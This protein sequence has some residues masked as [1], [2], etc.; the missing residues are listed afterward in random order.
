M[1]TEEVSPCGSMLQVFGKSALANA[2]FVYPHP[3]T[4]T[5]IGESTEPTHRVDEIGTEAR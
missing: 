3:T 1:G 2:C 4:L 5:I